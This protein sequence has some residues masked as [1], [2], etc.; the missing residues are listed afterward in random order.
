MIPTFLGIAATISLPAFG[1]T[2]HPCA[3]GTPRNIAGV[4]V[5]SIDPP[6]AGPGELIVIEGKG[7]DLLPQDADAWFFSDSTLYTALATLQVLDSKHALVIVPSYNL[8]DGKGYFGLHQTVSV[9]CGT[10]EWILGGWLAP[11]VQFRIDDPSPYPR[12]A[13]HLTAVPVS[14]D[15]VLLT[16]SDNS[17]DEDSFELYY[18]WQG[19][20][21]T[22]VYLGAVPADQ[23]SE[24]ITNLRPNTEYCFE[25]RSKNSGGQQQMPD[26][27]KACVRT[28]PQP[29]DKGEIT[30]SN[31]P[32]F[33]NVMCPGKFSVDLVA[34]Q[35]TNNNGILDALGTDALPHA[36]PAF[37]QIDIS[38]NPAW[39]IFV[40]NQYAPGADLIVMANAVANCGPTRPQ[41][42]AIH[43]DSQTGRVIKF[44]AG[45]WRENTGP[46]QEE[47][48][49]VMFDIEMVVGSPATNSGRVYGIVD[50]LVQFYLDAHITGSPATFHRGGQVHLDFSQNGIEVQDG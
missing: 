21:S 6:T 41:F 50:S 31:V 46:G 48:G 25:V 1:Q 30:V 18:G 7:F 43:I 29:P 37:P 20:A 40:S 8:M 22:G 28:Y 45:D 2:P 15:E 32:G 24:P 36:A 17:N 49:A 44:V 23:T 38:H 34:F 4:E 13:S 35:D 10:S 19:R 12:P 39:R 11:T 26:L 42:A 33:T 16:W 5:L 3:A 47:I 14:H 9:M 27:A